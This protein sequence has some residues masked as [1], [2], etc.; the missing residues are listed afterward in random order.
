[1]LSAPAV[2]LRELCCGA[3]APSPCRLPLPWAAGMTQFPGTGQWPPRGNVTRATGTDV[4]EP[5]FLTQSPTVRTATWQAS[6]SA[7]MKVTGKK[8]SM[9]KADSRP[10]RAG[11]ECR[12]GKRFPRAQVTW[13]KRQTLSYPSPEKAG[14]HREITAQMSP[15]SAFSPRS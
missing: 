13:N 12:E 11:T 6:G 7:E 1:M 9:T 3:S 5:D 15:K 4:T 14:T 2:N 10:D 8:G